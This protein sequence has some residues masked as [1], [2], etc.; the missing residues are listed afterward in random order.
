MANCPHGALGRHRRLSRCH[1][2]FI[3]D[4]PGKRFIDGWRV[5]ED[6]DSCHNILPEGAFADALSTS[7][8]AKRMLIDSR[9]SGFEQFPLGTVKAH[10]DSK[11][12][13]KITALA[14]KFDTDKN[15]PNPDRPQPEC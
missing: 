3:F 1:A 7:G 10:G 9:L 2:G 8:S 12:G 14:G 11:G 4:T 5:T 13:C 15:G 6:P